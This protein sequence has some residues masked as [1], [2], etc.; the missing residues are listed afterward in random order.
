[1]KTLE[2]I[3]LQ[4][5]SMLELL[6]IDDDDLSQ[7]R[8]ATSL[9][10]AKQGNAIIATADY[11]PDNVDAVLQYVETNLQ[12]IEVRHSVWSRFSE[13]DYK[14]AP[15]WVLRFPEVWIDDID[16][17]HQCEECT[18]PAVSV[19]PLVR[20]ESIPG[21]TH[22]AL[23]INGQ[24]SV[25]RTDVCE[26]LESKVSGC[27]FSPFDRNENYQYLL[28]QARLTPLIVRESES[29]G[30]GD[31]CSVCHLPTF[32]SFLGHFVF[33]QVPGMALTLRMQSSMTIAFSV[34]GQR[35]C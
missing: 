10:F 29:I 27:K 28:P 15:L 8:A 34:L 25:F 23:S 21:V 24:L 18:R 31:R 9:D 1:M 35:N 7:L 22:S 20:V 19:D 4:P 6:T 16:F 30:L 12:D 3:K 11:R 33:Q 26:A 13:E 14:Q 17:R 5:T 2:T 32:S